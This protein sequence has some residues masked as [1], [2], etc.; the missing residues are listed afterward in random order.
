MKK[1][2]TFYNKGKDQIVNE[3][4]SNTESTA[5]YCRQ[6]GSEI[7]TDVNFCPSCGS[8]QPD[9]AST[10]HSDADSPEQNSSISESSQDKSEKTDSTQATDGSQSHTELDSV[11]VDP[12]AL[13]FSNLNDDQKHCQSCG[14]SRHLQQRQ[15]QNCYTELIDSESTFGDYSNA[16]AKKC[17]ECGV[18]VP[19][20]FT[21]CYNCG[22]EK[23][24]AASSVESHENGQTIH[25]AGE[26]DKTTFEKASKVLAGTVY[27]SMLLMFA[28][29]FLLMIYLFIS[30]IFLGG[31]SGDF[32]AGIVMAVSMALLTNMMDRFEKHWD[33]F[34][35]FGNKIE[36][37]K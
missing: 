19:H 5:V 8:E 28:G 35:E 36:S 10:T 7:R 14:E 25:S 26:S 16:E 2:G 1:C 24:A 4:M 30:G 37:H 23:R 15:C 17:P 9:T 27:V 11:D 32:V 21:Y 12:S 3:I 6:C 34:D 22:S 29:A 18:G 13:L 31:S 33:A 20:E